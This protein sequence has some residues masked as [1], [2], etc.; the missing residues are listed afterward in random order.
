M[1]E[2]TNKYIIKVS[3]PSARYWQNLLL[4]QRPIWMNIPTINQLK[5][6]NL[7]VSN[8]LMVYKS[9]TELFIRGGKL[10]MS[11]FYMSLSFTVP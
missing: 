2:V 7:S 11:L 8:Q 5:T 6:K 3:K 1:L 10:N 9:V 4:H